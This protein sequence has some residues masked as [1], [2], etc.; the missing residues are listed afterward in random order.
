MNPRERL[1][2]AMRREV[3]DRVPYEF[4][5]SP[6]LTETFRCKTGAED[7]AEYYGFEERHVSF[8]PPKTEVDYSQYYPE[9]LSAQTWIDSWGVAREPG[10]EYHFSKM[11]HPLR[12]ATTVKDVLDY[13]LP[14]FHQVECW[15]HL[16]G[17]V[18]DLHAR[19]LAAHA[20]L[21]MTIFEIS[22]YIRGME[23]LFVDM[24][25]H[26]EMS[27]ALLE[28]ITDLRVFQAQTYARAD[29]DILRLGDDV[30]A[31]QGMLMSPGMWRQWLKPRLARVIEAAR[32]V[33][34]DIL[35][36]YHSDGDC[37]AIIPEL[38]ELGVDILNPVQ[39][40]CMDP[41]VIKLQYGSQ[42]SFSGT[43][44]TQ[45]TMPQGT[46]AEIKA[47]VKERIATVGKGG[48]LLLAPSHVLEPDVPWENVVAFVEA[49]E[50]YGWY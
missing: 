19:E 5:L 25:S 26:P 4:F 40:E 8:Y 16:E 18:A 9:G 46:P 20:L 27:E 34:P 41:A 47:T 30:A 1:L 2:T 21:G 32:S 12:R 15:G 35:I 7:P 45:T 23:N 14:D 13:P 48:G 36:W 44:G 28:R 31:Q 37:R 33:K 38:I 42:L 29:V 10:S 24:V 3:P 50:E 17:Q 43:I 6:A 49:V 22:W 11:I 39:P